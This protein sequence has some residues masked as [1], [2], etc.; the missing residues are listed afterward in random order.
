M[1]TTLDID[2]HLLEDAL[3]V[4]KERL[5]KAAVDAALTDFVR[6]RNIEELRRMIGTYEIDLT[7][8]EL[9]RMRGCDRPDSPD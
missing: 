2:E 6:A 1:R 4:T 3:R 5:K 9:A 7:P 8:E